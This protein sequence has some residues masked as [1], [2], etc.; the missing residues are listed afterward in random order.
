MSFPSNVR[1]TRAPLVSFAV[2]GVMWG[3]FAADLPDIKAVL[4]VSEARLGLLLFTTPFAAL[5]A[6]TLAPVAARIAGRWALVAATVAMALAF[7]LPGQATAD[8]AFLLAMLACGFATGLTDV[9]M[10]ARVSAIEAARGQS[11]MNLTHA[12][13]SFG[14]AGGAV[15]TG[16]LRA[17]GWT[18]GPLTLAISVAAALV[19]VLSYEPNGAIS[20]LTRPR[21]RSAAR[22]GLVPLIG[23]VMVFIA[24]LTENASENW[25]ALF[26]EQTLGGSPLHGAM[27]PAVMALTMGVARLVGQGFANRVTPTRLLTVA[28]M[29]GA[30]GL[31][32]A[33]SAAGPG[34]AYVGFVIA[35]IGL[36]LISPTAFSMVGVFSRPQ[37]RARSIAR[38]TMV[39]YLGYFVGPPGFGFLAGAVG[40][41]ATFVMAACLLATIVILVRILNRQAKRETGMSP[42]A[43]R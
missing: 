39:G 4:G 32:L 31:A 19:S 8:W 23:G 34:A 33:A 29:I 7:C 36:A 17:A 9:L 15:V 13:Y 1:A 35:G 26:I 37:A 16:T 42:P 2:M 12:A 11:L 27:G 43:P 22:L 20:G 10:N 30:G 40:L 24:F 41:R 38:A 14:Y 21:D 25:S 6:M 3:T 28:A 5:F 18:P